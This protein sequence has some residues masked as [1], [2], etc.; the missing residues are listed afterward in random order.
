[1]SRSRRRT[2]VNTAHDNC[3]VGTRASETGTGIREAGSDDACRPRRPRATGSRS[4]LPLLSRAWALLALLQ[5]LDLAALG[6]V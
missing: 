4:S 1:M 2:A 6:I 3:H 5:L